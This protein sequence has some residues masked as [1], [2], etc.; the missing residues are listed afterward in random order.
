M[1]Q[2]LS[3]EELPRLYCPLRITKSAFV[4]CYLWSFSVGGFV[5]L[6]RG[7]PKTP[8]TLPSSS[9]LLFRLLGVAHARYSGPRGLYGLCASDWFFGFVIVKL[10]DRGVAAFVPSV[11]ANHALM[12]KPCNRFVRFL[13]L[14][15][16]LP[17][18][19]VAAPDPMS[20]KQAEGQLQ[21][22]QSGILLFSRW[23]LTVLALVQVYFLLFGGSRAGGAP[24]KK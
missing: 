12:V 1:R 18:S 11:F 6:E 15:V 2:K 10:C 17:G 14:L 4:S 7:C 20:A 19:S 9:W 3:D 8:R 21:C 13:G 22:K 23:F 16:S 5:K 24:L